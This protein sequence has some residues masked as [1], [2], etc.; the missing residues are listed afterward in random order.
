MPKLAPLYMGFLQKK[1]LRPGRKPLSW[2]G[3]P[4][5]CFATGHHKLIAM[6]HRQNKNPWQRPCFAKNEKSK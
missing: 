3:R 4:F 6:A 1:S 5:L 2:K